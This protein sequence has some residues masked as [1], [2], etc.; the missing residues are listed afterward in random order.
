[1]QASG[2]I[3]MGKIRKARLRDIDGMIELWKKLVEY[4]RSQ[5][6]EFGEDRIPRIKEDV[7]EVVRNYFSRTIRSRNGFLLILEDNNIIQGY[8]LSRIQKNIPVFSKDSVGYISDI[9]LEESYRGK[10]YS[11]RMFNETMN[12]FN[13]KGIT[14]ISIRVMCC[15]A[16]AREVYDHWGFKGIDVT[17]R[18]DLD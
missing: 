3:A 12:W 8:M 9:Y 6:R 16:Q 2:L 4:Q 7:S 13:K 17:M 11:S 1:M 10:G 5:G 15:N 14:E 18:L